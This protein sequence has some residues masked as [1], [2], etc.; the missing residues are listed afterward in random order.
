MILVT[1]ATGFIGSHLAEALLARG[2]NVRALVRPTSSRRFLPR[3]DVICADLLTGA[4][5]DEAL[6]EVRT[7][8]HLAGATKALHARD[9]YTANVKATETLARRVAGKGIR[10]VHVSSLAAAGPSCPGAPIDEQ[11]QPH[12]VTHYG[13]SKLEGE[14][15][16]R[17]LVPDAVIVR[18]P[19]VYG[20][21]D[22]DVFQI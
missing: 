13:K 7:V 18:P 12:P 16:V 19:V 4:G 6:V 2:E 22:T 5:I 15:I 3:L 14:R 20:P 17:S 11:A 9:F 10:L 21:R 1:G 8:F